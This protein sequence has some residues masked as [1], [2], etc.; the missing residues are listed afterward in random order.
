MAT[1]RPL[2]TFRELFHHPRPPVELLRLTK[3]FAKGRAGRSDAAVPKPIA[4]VLYTLSIVVAITRWCEPDLGIGRRGAAAPNRLGI[5]AALGRRADPRS[6]SRGACRDRSRSLRHRCRPP[7]ATLRMSSAWARRWDNWASTA[8]LEK[9]GEGGMGTVYKALHTELDR[10]VAIKVMRRSQL[11]EDWAVARFRREIKAVGQ[12]DHPNIVRAHDARAIADTHFLVM[13]YVDGLDLH[14]LV[15]RCGPLPVA[16]ACELVRQA[17]LGLQCA[18]EHGLVHRDIKPSNLMLNRQGQVKIL[19]LGLARLQTAGLAGETTAV[20]QMMGT[21]DYMAP[22]QA[23]DSH[24]VDIR[25]DI[26]S[27]GCTLYKLLTGN[28]PFGGPQYQS[29]LAKMTAHR[30]RAPPSVRQFRDDVPEELLAVLDRMLAKSPEQRFATPA[31]VADALQPFS[32][33]SDLGKLLAKAEG[34]PAAADAADIRVSQT[35]A[36]P[37][38]RR[39]WTMAAGLALAVLAGGLLLWLGAGRAGR[40]GDSDRV[41]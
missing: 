29:L 5:R 31:E 3:D 28:A 21:P 10:L 30:D 13:E 40:S 26:Y 4:E 16:D 39:R 8:S 19:D 12:L 2:R 22:E 36:S 23:S 18:H 11:D 33:G 14:E 17:A 35:S 24:A 37:R 15:K 25:A 32:Q 9:L 41:W 7:A 6:A 1:R 38:R 27:L 34:R 20:G